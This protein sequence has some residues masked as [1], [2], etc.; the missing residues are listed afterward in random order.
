MIGP[1]NARG[2]GGGLNLK[3]VGGTTQPANPRENTIWVNTTT[4][5]TG[6]VLSPTQPETGTEGLVWIKTAD[7][8]VE[9]NVGKKNAVLL[10]L[11]DGKLYTGGAWTPMEGRVYVNSA[12][13]Q[14]AWDIIVL[15]KDG[16][17]ET[18]LSGG[19][20]TFVGSS[21]AASIKKNATNIVITAT[22]RENNNT[23]AFVYPKNKIDFTNLSTVTVNSDW[24]T[25]KNQGAALIYLAS[26]IANNQDVIETFAVAKNSN[27]LD[28]SKM[29]GEYYLCVGCKAYGNSG[30][31][32]VC[33]I[34]EMT[35]Q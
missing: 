18:E 3:V 16:V 11:A 26:K 8:G 32:V 35:L 19:L 33:T 27:T 14:F 5:I 22:H 12:W 34:K 24:I 1:T 30:A 21:S 20:S 4:A 25:S 17:E 9:I 31:K 6:Y 28:V 15:Y 13:T 23:S 29:S 10:H 2:G 7:T